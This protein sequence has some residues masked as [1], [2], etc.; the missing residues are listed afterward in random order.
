MEV[1]STF[2]SLEGA[3]NG[4]AW[5][6]F[7][8]LHFLYFIKHLLKLVVCIT[9]ETYP[10]LIHSVTLSSSALFFDIGI[11]C[12]FGARLQAISNGNRTEWSPIRSVI[13]RVITKSDDCAAILRRY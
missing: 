8:P 7:I 12:N 4:H 5:E 9:F 1:L 11:L 10:S 3:Q 6:S 2:F 13:I